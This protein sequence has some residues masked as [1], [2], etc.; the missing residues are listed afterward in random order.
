MAQWQRLICVGNELPERG[1]GVRFSIQASEGTVP[2]FAVRYRGNVHAYRNTCAH[3]RVELDGE[4]G[5]FFDISGLYLVC[6]S[7]G[8]AYL[9]DTG[10]C[11]GGPCKGRRLEKLT[12][13]EIDGNV[14][15]LDSRETHG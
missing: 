5:R 4:P 10:V 15:L 1:L 3:A 12:V 14:Y 13:Q 11:V 8:A 7:H 9:P 2:A 6:A